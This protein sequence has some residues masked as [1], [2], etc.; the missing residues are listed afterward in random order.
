M[1]LL[2]EIKNLVR[3]FRTGIYLG[4]RF[5]A[6]D[7]VNIKLEQSKILTIAGESGCGKSTLAKII[8]GYLKPTYG[9]VIYKEKDIFNLKGKEKKWFRHEVQPVFQDPFGTFNPFNKVEYYL[10]NTAINFSNT[11]K[12]EEIYNDIEEALLSVG[13]SLKTVYGKYPHEFSGGELQRLS[14]ARALITKPSLLIAD[15]PVSMLDASLRIEILNLMANLKQKFGL[16]IIYITHDLSTSYYLGTITGEE[17]A[18]MYRGSIIE[19]G[20][21]EKTLIEPLHPYTK[22][23]VNSVPEPNPKKR[24]VDRVKFPPLEI[25]EFRKVGCKFVER[26][27][28]AKEICE[29]QKPKVK[30]ID[31]REVRC[32]QY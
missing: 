24:W 31:K 7:D 16:S 25:K 17:I 30:L 29:K 18:V 15:E 11:K 28:Y 22:M 23:L 19:Y 27:P 13:L 1:S 32:W 3:E 6:V 9:Y 14:I 21:V 5:R 26:C 20:P 10:L 8:L 2:L 12:Q 4:A